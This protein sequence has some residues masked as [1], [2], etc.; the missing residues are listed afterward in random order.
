MYYGGVAVVEALLAS[1]VDPG[2]AG[3]RR[4]DDGHSPRRTLAGHWIFG[5]RVARTIN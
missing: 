2:S 1:G 5:F 3:A 4:D